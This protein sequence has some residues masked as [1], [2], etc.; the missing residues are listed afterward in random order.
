MRRCTLSQRCV[1]Q[2]LFPV[3]LVVVY[4]VYLEYTL[5]QSTGLIKYNTFCLG[6]CLQIIRPFYKYSR[7]AGSSDTGEETQWDTYYQCAR[8]ADDEECKCTVDPSAPFCR[9]SHTKHPHKRR[10]NC[11]CDGTVYHCRGIDPCKF[12]NEVFGFRFSGACIFHQI[13]NF[14]H[15]GFAE[16]FGRLYLQHARHIDASADD[17]VALLCISRQ[18]LS[19]QCTCV[20]SRRSFY[21][22]TIDRNLLPRL[23]HDHGTGLYFVRIDLFQFPVLFNIGVI[24]TDVHQV[25]DISAA[26]AN[27]ITLEPLADLIEQHNRYGFYIIPCF[28]FSHFGIYCNCDRADRGYRH[29]QALVKRL[30]VLDS[31]KCFDQDIIADHKIRDQ[32]EDKSQNPFERQEIEPDQQRCRSQD[33]DQHF[34]LFFIHKSF[35]LS[36]YRKI[37]QSS[38]TFLQFLRTSCITD[39]AS[40]PSSNS[41]FIFSVIKFTTASFT[42]SVFLAACSILFAQ[43][44]QSTSIL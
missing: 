17:L 6:Q 12:S 33:P 3:H 35:L 10:K 36:S 37:S 22:D 16:L 8:T 40:C 43:F 19:C 23:H 29:Q 42:P 34:F 39:F 31:F 26:F 11:K 32:I 2:Q 14:R 18:A 38:S 7:I 20:E 24:G 44:A 41:T 25:T 5:C 21:D 15:R 1:F 13:Q 30:T 28:V 9:D 27:S 4:L